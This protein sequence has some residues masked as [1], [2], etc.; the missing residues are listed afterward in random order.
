MMVLTIQIN[1]HSLFLIV[2]AGEGNNQEN[3]QDIF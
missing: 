1:N 3:K 2:C